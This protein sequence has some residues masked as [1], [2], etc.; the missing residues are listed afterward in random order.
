MRTQPRP[1]DK[2]SPLNFPAGK[3]YGRNLAKTQGHLAKRQERVLQ[4]QEHMLSE[5]GGWLLEGEEG[6]LSGSH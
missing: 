5:I 3:D 4:E 2:P 6:G 1:F